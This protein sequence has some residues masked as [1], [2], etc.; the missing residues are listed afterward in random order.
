[1]K[2]LGIPEKEVI[3]CRIEKRGSSYPELEFENHLPNATTICIMG[4]MENHHHHALPITW[5]KL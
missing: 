4:R 2:V 5:S 1:M 3:V